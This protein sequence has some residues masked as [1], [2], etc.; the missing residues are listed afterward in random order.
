MNNELARNP[1]E[2]LKPE[3]KKA[4]EIIARNIAE[5]QS[6]KRLRAIREKVYELLVNC[7]PGDLI[8]KILMEELCTIA[9]E[10]FGPH[11]K[12]QIIKWVAHYENMLKKG[13]KDM[14]HIEAMIARVMV[15]FKN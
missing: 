14:F 8:M 12:P 15:L 10:M 2:T 6:P 5:E 3:W 4:I 11:M 7:I 13:S 1:Q 9:E